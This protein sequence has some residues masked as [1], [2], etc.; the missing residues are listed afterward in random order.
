MPVRM[1]PIHWDLHASNVL[2]RGSDAIVIDFLSNKE[3]PVLY[4]AACLEASLLIDGFDKDS[5]SPTWDVGVWLES[6]EPLYRDVSLREPPDHPHPKVKSSW[7]HACV[8]QIRLH[9]LRMECKS[10]QYAGALAI[11][12]LKK[13]SKDFGASPGEESRRA[14]AYLLAERILTQPPWLS[15]MTVGP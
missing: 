1:G 7:F 8:R 15:A 3:G 6:I 14:V 10:G 2:V 11:A 12:L 13:A 4:D 9:A 5:D